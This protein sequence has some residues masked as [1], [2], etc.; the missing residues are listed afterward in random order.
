[1]IILQI[2]FNLIVENDPRRM[3]FFVDTNSRS[4]LTGFEGHIV[5]ILH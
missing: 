2:R 5:F 4:P 1:M 3:S